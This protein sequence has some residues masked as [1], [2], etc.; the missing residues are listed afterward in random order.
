MGNSCM[1]ASS[2]EWDGEDWESLEQ[3]KPCS[4]SSSSSSSS[5]V[6]DEA[7][8]LDHRQ[9]KE[10]NILGKLRAS[11]DANGKVTLKIS[12]CELAELLGA[13]LQNNN[14]NHQQPQLVMKKKKELASAEQ[15]LFRLMKARNHEIEKKH[16]GS[17]Q[18]KPMLETIPE[19]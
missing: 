13:I 9:N 10:N 12:K 7:A 4:S 8:Y 3:P 5:K 14:K 16:H 19:C 17:G 1:A 18:W 2:M 15:I 6:L 11:C